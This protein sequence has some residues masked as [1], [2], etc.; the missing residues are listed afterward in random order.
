MDITTLIQA[1]L[2]GMNFKKK[3]SE[4]SA[5]PILKYALLSIYQISVLICLIHQNMKLNNT[6]KFR[7]LWKSPC[8]RMVSVR[9][10]VQQ[11]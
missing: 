9:I 8:L 3:Q 1:A 6:V 11:M 5:K 4:I 10:K 2:L 7:I